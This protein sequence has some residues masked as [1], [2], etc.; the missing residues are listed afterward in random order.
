MLAKSV[1]NLLQILVRQGPLEVCR[2]VKWR[3]YEKRCERRLGIATDGVIAAAALGV[4]DP[5][6]HYYVATDYSTLR[7][8][9]DA[10]RVTDQDVMVDF[11]AGKGRA[12]IF[13]GQWPFKRIVGVEISKELCNEA[14]RNL[15]LAR[16]GRG[17][18]DDARRRLTLKFWH[19]NAACF[20]IPADMTVAFF[21]NPFSGAALDEVLG[22]IH[23]SVL[24][25]PRR[26][27]VVCNSHSAASGFLQRLNQC[28]WLKM[29]R[30]IELT[31][32]GHV[33][34]IY[35]T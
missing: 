16:W 19:C 12:C 26:I 35:C 20:S 34:T 28:S 21:F 3:W 18:T 9:F 27:H 1:S 32:P 13:A 31:A 17:A 24:A 14:E 15:A 4:A 25:H 8:L 11:G 2:F 30:Q 5:D 33:G 29:E 22:N 6:A 10:L 7:T 23:A